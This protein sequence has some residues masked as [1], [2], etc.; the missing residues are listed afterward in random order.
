MRHPRTSGYDA[1]RSDQLLRISEVTRILACSRPTVYRLIEEGAL[2]PIYLDRRPRFDPADLERLVEERRG[3]R[4]TIVQAKDGK[5]AA[6]ENI[7]QRIDGDAQETE[8]T[9]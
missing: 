8:P 3:R 9:I 4:N 2:T 6:V 7:E 1:S 5:C